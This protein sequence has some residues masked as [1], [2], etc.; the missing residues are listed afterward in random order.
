MFK[1]HTVL[2]GLLFICNAALPQK[3][4]SSYSRGNYEKALSQA[5]KA[6]DDDSKNLDAYLIK[7][8][9]YLHLATSE[10][11]KED[12]STGIESSLST[13][14]FL[15]SKDKQKTFFP[16]HQQEV[17]SVIQAASDYAFKLYDNNKLSRADKLIDKL[18]ELSPKPEHYFL[19]G[20]LM[21]EN[22]DVDEAM[23][24]Y[25]VAASKIYLDYKNGR[26]TSPYLDEAFISLAQSLYE[27]FDFDNAVIIYVR[28]LDVFKNENVEDAC[29]EMFA[30]AASGL[31]VFSGAE[32]FENYLKNIDT[33]L[34]CVKN[35]KSFQELKWT[36]VQGYYVLLAESAEFETAD[37]LM[38]A[39]ACS[40]EAALFI[41]NRIIKQ[42][43]I[44]YALQEKKIRDAKNELP[45][46]LKLENCSGAQNANEQLFV[47]LIDSFE[48]EHKYI[49]ASRLL[50]NLK[51]VSQNK[52]LLIQ[53][54][55]NLVQDIKN[56]PDSLFASIDLYEIMQYF[57][58]NKNLKALQQN[59]AITTIDKYIRLKKFTEA[60]ELLRN[61]IKLY[62]KDASLKSLLKMWVIED[63]KA[64]YLSSDL[65][66]TELN[67]SGNSDSCEAG[68]IS[69]IAD[70]KLLQRLNYV[71]RL[72]GLPDQCVLRDEWN[73]K[74]QA[75]ALMMTANGSL[76]HNP[77]KT[78]SC[79]TDEGY[80][81]ASRSNLALGA[82]GVDGLMLQLDDGGISSAGH[83]RWILNPY[84]KVFGH[85]ST[86]NAMA[87]W[88][89]GGEN[90]D[91]PEAITEKFETQFVAWPPEGYVP[92]DLLTS[93]WSFALDNSNFETTV[94]EMTKGNKKIE[95]TI[96]EQEFGYG[97]NTLV[98]LVADLGFFEKEEMVFTVKLK[99]VGIYDP[100][101]ENTYQYKDFTYTVSFIPVYAN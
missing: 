36:A 68:K 59:A 18:I 54:E 21:M 37:S 48:A 9:S 89:L 73:K 32:K 76:S 35:V 55:E 16:A 65:N 1:T 7:S 60:G 81:G 27:E 84:R 42:T 10:D 33:I 28:A 94:V 70:Q 17:D 53:T 34:P 83:R 8:L 62:P 63:Y 38:M 77:P 87:L 50:Y 78:W 91:Y 71:R 86:D 24:L 14:K 13:L 19:K 20:K 23:K 2:I 30:D 15:Y 45:I 12:Y 4:I 57:P 80:S 72:A 49:E 101:A 51:L 99:H 92:M 64:N 66:N 5:Q 52:N 43:E 58:A 98:W 3:F 61:Q 75:A 88:A 6:I 31:G 41:R 96:Y 56:E 85:G 69:K 100:G 46:L 90:A 11:T 67:W 97:Q 26:L 82:S 40:N 25:N 22:D 29:Y 39:Q 44:V 95:C 79:Y 74:C 47:E 93:L